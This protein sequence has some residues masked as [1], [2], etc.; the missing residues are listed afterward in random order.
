MQVVST[1]LPLGPVVLSS[2]PSLTGLFI[3]LP[4]FLGE[5][6]F[7]LQGMHNQTLTLK[8]LRRMGDGFPRALAS[9][10]LTGP[11]PCSHSFTTAT[12]RIA[13]TSG[14]FDTVGRSVPSHAPKQWA[15]APHG[16]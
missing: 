11:A 1:G 14:T 9:S 16:E 13:R 2:L 5:R 6:D 3:P 4:Q 15:Q 10:A 7:L 8:C 12:Y